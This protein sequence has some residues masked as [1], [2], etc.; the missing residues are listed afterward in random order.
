MFKM[1]VAKGKLDYFYTWGQADASKVGHRDKCKVITY[2]YENREIVMMMETTNADLRPSLYRYSS[3][4][5]N[6][7]LAIITM[8]ENGKL[9]AG[10]NINYF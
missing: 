4:K 1:S 5:F 6:T 3:S 7:D 8:S 10:Y 9:L 2:D